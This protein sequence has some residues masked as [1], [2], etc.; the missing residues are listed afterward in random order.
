MN[1]AAKAARGVRRGFFQQRVC[2]ICTRVHQS[3]SLDKGR[4]GAASISSVTNGIGAAH[5]RGYPLLQS[6]SPL[7]TASSRFLSSSQGPPNRPPLPP[8]MHPESNKAGHYLAQYTTDWTA[9][10][11]EAASKSSSSPSSSGTVIGR[12]DE[13]QRCLQILARRTKSNPVL[14]GDAGVG[15]TA[16][17]EGLGQ[18]IQQGLVPDSMKN[19]RLLALDLTALMAG[20]YSWQDY[21]HRDSVV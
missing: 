1:V 14:I 21:M 3:I 5:L 13:I 4:N 20:M 16:I 9:I 12:H 2:G 8:W 15:K 19:K 7:M 10:A 18:R 6:M 11:A 17:V